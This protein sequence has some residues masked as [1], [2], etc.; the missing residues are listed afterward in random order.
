VLRRGRGYGVAGVLGSDT[1]EVD[2]EDGGSWNLKV[3]RLPSFVVCQWLVDGRVMFMSMSW[4]QCLSV[5]VV[6]SM[7][8]SVAGR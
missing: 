8:L 4:Y 3:M 7:S 5:H 1:G 6:V 2:K